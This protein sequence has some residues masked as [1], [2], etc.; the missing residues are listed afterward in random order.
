MSELK[1]N[2]EIILDKPFDVDIR[3]YS[4]KQVDMFLDVVY[5]DYLSFETTVAEMQQ[6]IQNLKTAN[7]A[8]QKQLESSLKNQ[9]VSN[10]LMPTETINTID[11]L[12]R[13]AKLEQ[14]VYNAK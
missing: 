8:L 1:L 6:E 7:D 2:S 11:I 14:D 5:S 13:L 3:G 4:A 10:E 9:V 12:K